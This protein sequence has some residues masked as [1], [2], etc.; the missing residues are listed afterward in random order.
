LSLSLFKIT[1][2]VP[3]HVVHLVTVVTVF[4]AG[5]LIFI[6][7]LSFTS[8]LI[9][10]SSGETKICVGRDVWAFLSFCMQLSQRISFGPLRLPWCFNWVPHVIHLF[11]SCTPCDGD[12]WT[13]PIDSPSEWCSAG[14]SDSALTICIWPRFWPSEIMFCAWIMFGCCVTTVT[15]SECESSWL[16]VRLCWFKSVRWG[17]IWLQTSH[18]KLMLEMVF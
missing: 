12:C 15:V 2:P 9:S 14:S 16:C 13:I 17:N 6:T 8:N 18:L 4:F 5:W 11:L 1:T 3:L 10:P 7:L